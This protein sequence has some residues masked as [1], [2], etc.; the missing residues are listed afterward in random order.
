MK[1]IAVAD[2]LK[3]INTF[4]NW[5]RVNE[6]PNLCKKNKVLVLLLWNTLTLIIQ[7]RRKS[8]MSVY[9]QEEEYFPE[10]PQSHYEL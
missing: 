10:V 3:Y 5:L 6:R 1:Q 4:K 9:N 2:K 8:T 7:Y